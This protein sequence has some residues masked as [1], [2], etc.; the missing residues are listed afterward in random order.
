MEIEQL[1][2][3][4]QTLLYAIT[5]SRK[6][7]VGSL[8]NAYICQLDRQECNAL[9]NEVRRHLT[10]HSSKAAKCCAQNENKER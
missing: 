7:S 5:G 2:N 10:S 9:L 3:D 4:I 8:N 6:G 1:L